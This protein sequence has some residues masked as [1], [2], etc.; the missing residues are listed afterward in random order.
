MDVC[1]LLCSHLKPLGKTS[2]HERN[3]FYDRLDSAETL[4][5]SS[6]YPDQLTMRIL[7]QAKIIQSPDRLYKAPKKLD[8]DKILD[9][10]QK[11]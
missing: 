6:L 9:K 5:I 10:T 3:I 1:E 11:H 8:Q 2:T 4:V 7:S